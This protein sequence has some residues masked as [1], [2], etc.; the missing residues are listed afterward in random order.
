MSYEEKCIFS[1]A[2]V[3]VFAG[4]C[5]VLAVVITGNLVLWPLGFMAVALG[6]WTAVDIYHLWQD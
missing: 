5:A 4:C 3:L 1:A 2:Y 6:A